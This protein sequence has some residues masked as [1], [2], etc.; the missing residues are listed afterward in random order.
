MK[1]VSG[2]NSGVQDICLFSGEGYFAW[3][4]TFFCYC[5][6][7]AESPCFCGKNIVSSWVYLFLFSRKKYV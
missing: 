2:I 7:Y 4:F 1:L 3:F 6:F 5:N